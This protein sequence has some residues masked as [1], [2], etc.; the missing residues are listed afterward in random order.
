MLLLPGAVARAQ[1]PDVTAVEPTETMPPIPAAFGGRPITGFDVRGARD[2]EAP[3]VVALLTSMFPDGTPFV[4]AGPADRAGEPVG[5][6][7]QL[8]RAVDA[9]G[10]DA[11][12]QAR[13]AAA[14]LRLQIFLRAYHRVRYIFVRG[15]G[16]L[17]QDEIQRRITFRPG[18]PLPLPG[19]DRD[20][21]LER[22]RGR[23][24]EYL[25]GEGYFD[26]DAR[27]TLR[28]VA[29]HPG[30]TDVTINV[31]RGSSYPLGPLKVN[32]NTV[33]PAE[34]IDKMFR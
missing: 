16:T 7:P 3:K 20:T 6:V 13:P 17:R 32:G 5:T 25:R 12:V 24:V 33:F 26:A 19:P 21:A 28:A 9:I 22:E 11:A 27:I 10:Y 1:E 23:V 18:R 2:G 29:D 15:N 8:R 4:P 30:A 34:D 14:G 31:S